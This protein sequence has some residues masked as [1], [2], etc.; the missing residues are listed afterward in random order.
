ML[1]GGW[2]LGL[3]VSKSLYR[4]P[5]V[6]CFW[7]LSSKFDMVDIKGRCLC[8]VLRVAWFT[9]ELLA[10]RHVLRGY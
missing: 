8:Q 5:T 10:I 1:P 9:S 2:S 4:R 7:Q 6:D 3:F